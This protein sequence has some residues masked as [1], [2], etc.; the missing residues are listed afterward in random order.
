[1]DGNTIIFTLLKDDREKEMLSKFQKIWM[2]KFDY[3]NLT[4]EQYFQYVR[5]LLIK[6]IKEKQD[7][8]HNYLHVYVM[9][10][11]KNLCLNIEDDYFPENINKINFILE[12]KYLKLNVHVVI[13]VDYIK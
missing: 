4:F 6:N 12:K 13:Y 11:I 5:I 1:M 3:E 2:K 10:M 7:R 9:E 8:K